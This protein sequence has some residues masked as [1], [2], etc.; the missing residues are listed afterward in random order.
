[1]SVDRYKIGLSVNG[2]EKIVECDDTYPDVHDWKSAVDFA[3]R[4]VKYT[5]LRKQTNGS[6]HRP[7]NEIDPKIELLFCE[8]WESEEYKGY[9]YVHDTPTVIM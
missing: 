5:H 3:F 8:D 7:L 4:L 9:D 1:M 2:T 6:P